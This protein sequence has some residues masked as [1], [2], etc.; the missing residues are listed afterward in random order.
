MRLQG[1]RD[2]MR[3]GQK[4]RQP[5]SKPLA[6][7]RRGAAGSTRSGANSSALLSSLDLAGD[8]L[9]GGFAA[10]AAAQIAPSESGRSEVSAPGY[11]AAAAAHATPPRY[12]GAGGG[13]GG[14]YVP[15]VVEPEPMPEGARAPTPSLSCRH[16]ARV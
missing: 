5:K 13:G 14:G 7:N 2:Y 15:L 16:H 4:P 1:Y 8:D 3:T 11:A 12:G 6:F 10:T 9:A